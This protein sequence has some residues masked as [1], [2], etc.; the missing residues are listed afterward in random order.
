MREIFPSVYEVL[1]SKQTPK[2]YRTFFVKRPEGNLLIPCFSS[3]STIDAHFA[4]MDGLGGLSRQLLGDSHFKTAHCDE[5]ATRFNAPLYCSE[6]EAPDVRAT[7]KQVV[8]F[9]FQRHQLDAGIEVIPTP[10]HRAGGVC[11]LIT[12]GGRRYLFVGDFIWH[13]GAQWLPTAKKDSVRA[14]VESLRLVDS[15]DFD[16]LLINAMLSNPTC[17]I[18]LTKESRHTLIAGLLKHYDKS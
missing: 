16:V 7:V 5:I 1:P 18:E 6:V 17:F 9:P 3:S 11:Y 2:K 4:T 12:V 15:L 14:Y 8:T 13:D 10:G